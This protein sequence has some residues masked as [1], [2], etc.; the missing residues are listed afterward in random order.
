M[1]IITSEILVNRIKTVISTPLIRVEVASITQLSDIDL[2]KYYLIL[3][4]VKIDQI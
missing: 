3:S 1:G 4:T 2:S